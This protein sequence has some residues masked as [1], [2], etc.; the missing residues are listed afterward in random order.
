MQEESS[1]EG[2]RPLGLS[3]ELPGFQFRLRV[4]DLGFRALGVLWGFIGFMI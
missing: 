1:H 3:P 2:W 4:Q